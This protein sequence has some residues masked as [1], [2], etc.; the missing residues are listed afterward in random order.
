MD[1]LY[2]YNPYPEL[3]GETFY[4]NSITNELKFGKLP[5][6]LSSSELII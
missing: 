4:H 2:M 3:D 6:F 1:E 5:P